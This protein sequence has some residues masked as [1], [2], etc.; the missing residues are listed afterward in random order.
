MDQGIWAT[1]YDLEEGD[2]A[3]FLD[4]M[5]GEY[6]PS[7]QSRPGFAW[8]AHY[9]SDG[10]GADMAKV[11]ARV[12]HTDAEVPGGTQFLLLVGAPSTHTF[13]TPNVV[14]RERAETGRTGEMLALRRGTRSCIF[15][16]EARVNGPSGHLRPLGTTP[17][18]AIQMG[19]FRTRN[20]DDE[21]DAGSWYAQDRLPRMAGMAGCIG[22]RKL[23]CVAGWP[24]HGILYEWVSLQARLEGFEKTVEVAGLDA[25]SWTA[26]LWRNID[27]APGSPTVARRIWPAMG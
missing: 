15:L 19:S 8:V 24:K 26:R 23:A 2:R 11:R 20:F 21:S 14:Q 1:W 5:H 25:T 18:A 12:W 4:W 3:R 13:Y 27:H 17:G 22:A 7:L 10:G 9:E 6:A 16:E